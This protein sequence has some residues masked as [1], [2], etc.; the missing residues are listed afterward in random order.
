[1]REEKLK[2]MFDEYEIRKLLERYTRG[3][4]RLDAALICSV[5]HEKSTDD[6]G[7]YKGS[8]ADFGE[9]VTEL[10][11]KET[12]STMHSLNQSVIDVD[13]DNAQAETYFVAYHVR[14]DDGD[15]YLDRFG[16]RYLDRL[17]RHFGQWRIDN[18]VVVR[19]WSTTEKIEES[20]YMRGDFVNGRRDKK[21]LAYTGV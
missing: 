16:G 17:R 10:L 13:G 12:E 2:A 6:H 21:D 5:Y 4:D 7:P 8:G 18:R 3:V 14:L 9:F 11:G 20:Q 1:M 15:E 19:E